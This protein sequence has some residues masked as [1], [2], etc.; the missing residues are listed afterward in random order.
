M[1][2]LFSAGGV[3]KWANKENMVMVKRIQCRVVR[4]VSLNEGFS[5]G[6]GVKKS[7]DRETSGNGFGAVDSK[8]FVYGKNMKVI[9]DSKIGG[10]ID[11]SV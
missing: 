6:R 10:R 9:N 3:L 4:T 11:F 7:A 5:D 1:F 8:A 2:F